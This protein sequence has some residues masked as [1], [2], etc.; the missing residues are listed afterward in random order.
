MRIL[1]AIA[2]S[3]AIASVGCTT[4]G[5]NAN[6]SQNTRQNSSDWEQSIKSKLAS[7]PK[8]AKRKIDVSADPGKNQ[9]TLSGTVYSKA[10]RMEAI[11]DAKAARPGV[12]VVDSIKLKPRE[13]P[14]RAYTGKM[15]NHEHE[16]S[17]ANG[18]KLGSSLEDARIHT[19][20][21]SKLIADTKVTPRRIKIDVANGVVT[22]RGT[23]DSPEAKAKASSMA[24][25][26]VGVKKVNNLLTV[27]ARQS[28]ISEDLRED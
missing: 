23:V 12:K 17:K 27:R 22:L 11:N 1:P 13:I 4:T 8:I 24:M 15:A 3:A 26:T 28:R 20:I 7:D 5:T 2:L 25:R 18:D 9:V 19:K 21:D 10:E 14:K 6:T 16:R